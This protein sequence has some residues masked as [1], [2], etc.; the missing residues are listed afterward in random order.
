MQILFRLFVWFFPALKNS[1][2]VIHWPRLGQQEALRFVAA[3]FLDEV[4]LLLGLHP[5]HQR[6]DAHFLGHLDQALHQLAVGPVVVV[7]VLNE[8]HVNLD[9]VKV[10]F[11]QVIQAGVARTVTC[12][13]RI[14][15]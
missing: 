3:D 7:Q 15:W 5:F 10:I 4:I 12:S 8:L 2:E 14:T 9:Q 1:A 13:P 6:K 11:I